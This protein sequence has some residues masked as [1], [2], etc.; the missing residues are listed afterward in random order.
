MAEVDDL[1]EMCQ[2][3][4]KELKRMTVAWA[5]LC[6]GNCDGL[7]RCSDEFDEAMKVVKKYDADFSLPFEIR[8]IKDSQKPAKG[9]CP[10]PGWD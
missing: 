6:D 10:S 2:E 1:R 5:F 7:I 4:L 9:F 3:L 8:K